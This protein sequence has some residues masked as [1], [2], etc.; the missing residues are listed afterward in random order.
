[1]SS[2][3]VKPNI[4]FGIIVAIF[5]AI[6]FGIYPAAARGAYADGANIAFIVLLTTFFRAS[7]FSV[8]CLFTNKGIFKK[9]QLYKISVKGALWQSVSIIGVIGGCY[10]IEGPLV[11]CILHMNTIL[12]LFY[13]G[14]KGEVSL[15]FLTILSTLIALIGLTLVL[16]VW[17]IH[18]VSSMLG[19]ALAFLGTIATANR[20]YIFNSQMSDRHPSVV[21]AETFILTFIFLLPILFWTLPK[22]PETSI[23][24]AY[25]LFSGFSLGLGSLLIF[26]SIALLG[27]FRTSLFLKI[28]PV[29][30]TLFSLWFLG[31]YLKISQYI[32][33]GVVIASLIA[34]QVLSHNKEKKLQLK[35]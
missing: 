26:Y 35:N 5:S 31:E 13:M 4:K 29:F 10:Y 24:L 3:I 34:Y 21:G 23:G 25:A 15:D 27:G 16:D 7:F 17:S 1:M 12:L 11:L 8:H 2:E 18:S 28:E 22:L 32:G 30:T 33:M 20:V 9:K 6:I 19:I 14:R